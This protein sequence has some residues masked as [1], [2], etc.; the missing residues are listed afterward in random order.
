MIIDN[1]YNIY[2]PAANCARRGCR[3][4]SST[5]TTVNIIYIYII[6]YDAGEKPVKKRFIETRSD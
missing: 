6:F 5:A 4:A 3:L 1:N 2:R